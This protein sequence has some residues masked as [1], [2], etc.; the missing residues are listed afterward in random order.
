MP[1]SF[2]LVSCR[3]SNAIASDIFLISF[4]IY[5]GVTATGFAEAAGCAE[6][7]LIGVAAGLP[8]NAA[9]IVAFNCFLSCPGD[10]SNKYHLSV[11]KYA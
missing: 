10:L 11:K 9:S 7:G 6:T 1:S 4:P 2:V 3:P 8:F 5:L